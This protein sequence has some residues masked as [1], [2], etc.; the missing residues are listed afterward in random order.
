[1]LMWAYPRCDDEANL[2]SRGS[3]TSDLEFYVRRLL[4]E[5]Q[6]AAMAVDPDAKRSHMALAASYLEKAHACAA[7]DGAGPTLSSSRKALASA[8]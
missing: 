4:Q 1:M 8:C 6:A 3:M 7:T 5:R 2:G